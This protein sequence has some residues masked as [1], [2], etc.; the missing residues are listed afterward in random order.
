MPF[1]VQ[2]VIAA[3]TYRMYMDTLI[4]KLNFGLLVRD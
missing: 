3:A 4:D 2:H 1:N